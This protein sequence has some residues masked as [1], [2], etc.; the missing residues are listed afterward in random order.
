M[1]DRQQKDEK[2]KEIEPG[3]NEEERRKKMGKGEKG[4]MK[5]SKR[6]TGRNFTNK[7]PN[8]IGKTNK[9]TDFFFFEQAVELLR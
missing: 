8:G 6:K 2:T 3:G 5:K 9:E 1:W 4:D 7:N